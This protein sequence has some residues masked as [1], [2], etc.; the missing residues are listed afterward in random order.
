MK[1]VSISDEAY[2][3]VRAHAH[4]N[5]ESESAAL[6]ELF[7]EAPAAWCMDMPEMVKPWKAFRHYMGV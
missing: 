3:L 4:A 1:S 6:D 2:A 7:L 5:D